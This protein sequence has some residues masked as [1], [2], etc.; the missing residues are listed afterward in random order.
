M[1]RKTV[2]ELRDLTRVQVM[3]QLLT[4]CLFKANNT[5][6]PPGFKEQQEEY[7]QSATKIFGKDHL[8]QDEGLSGVIGDED[9]ADTSGEETEG[10]HP[11][12]TLG[13][14]DDVVKEKEMA[15][16]VE[17]NEESE[18]GSGESGEES[19]AES[20][21]LT[22]KAKVMV[23]NIVESEESTKTSDTMSVDGEESD[24][25]SDE[26]GVYLPTKGKKRSGKQVVKT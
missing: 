3:S 4:Y 21:K 7:R 20:G 15:Q 11:N 1:L 26:A 17:S 5:I 19:E 13:R 18:M 6:R 2:G 14:D 10:D 12:E 23:P 8:G 25:E 22:P 9:E 24:N 16:G